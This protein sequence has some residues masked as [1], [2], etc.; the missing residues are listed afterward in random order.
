MSDVLKGSDHMYPKSSFGDVTGVI[1]AGGRSRRYGKNK[2]LVEIDGI[3]LI[4]RVVSVMQ[5]VFQHLILITNT[6]DEYSYL[7]LPMYEDLIKGLGPLGG[8]FTALTTITNEAGFLVACDMPSLNRELIHHMVKVRD[9]FDAVVPRI[10]GNTEALH[11]LYCKRCLP[12]IRRLVDSREYQ[13]LRFFPKVSVR[14]V[15]ENEIR[16]FDPELRSFFNVNRPQELGRI[17]NRC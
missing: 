17:N 7:K 2:A 14:Y 1:L 15:D 10:R 11:A 5:S 3:P 4:E 13:V 16:R 9:D 12:A 8:I 6:P